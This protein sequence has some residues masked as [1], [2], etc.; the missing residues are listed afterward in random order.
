MALVIETPKSTTQY[1]GK[2]F[3]TSAVGTLEV[4]HSANINAPNI[5]NVIILEVHHTL[6]S[7]FNIYLNR[8]EP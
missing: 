3:I 7:I 4:K 1:S 2:I 5:P 6:K 8:K